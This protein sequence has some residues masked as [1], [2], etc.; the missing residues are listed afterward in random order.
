MN[1][2]CYQEKGPGRNMKC[3]SIDSVSVIYK[4]HRKLDITGHRGIFQE[5]NVLLY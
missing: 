3:S 5:Y 4:I 1:R 2:F